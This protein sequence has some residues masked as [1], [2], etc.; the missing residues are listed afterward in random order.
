MSRD[1]L[2]HGQVHVDYGQFYVICGEDDD[3]D[4]ESAFRGQ[5]NGL[6]GAAR[7]GSLFLVT[8][9]RNGPVEITVER[10]PTAPTV[11]DSWEEVVEVSFTAVSNEVA[12]REWD[13]ERYDLA[14]PAGDYRVRYCARGMQ[15]GWDL[16]TVYDDRPV[17]S[18]L[19]Q[20]WPAPACP[21]RIVRQT[22]EI[23][24]HW[25]RE[26][27]EHTGG[28]VA[29]AAALLRVGGA[30]EREGIE[31]QAGGRDANDR[32]SA[33]TIYLGDIRAL[34]ERLLYKLAEVDDATNRAVA[35]W[36]ALRALTAAGLVEIPALLP[37]VAALRSG[38][39]VPAPFDDEFRVVDMLG[40]APQTHVEPI[41]RLVSEVVDDDEDP[42]R[43]LNALMAVVATAR[44]NALEAALDAV[45]YAAIAHGG[46]G[47]ERL[48]HELRATFPELASTTPGSS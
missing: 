48:L 14:L 19:L 25:H 22:S 1:A 6:C 9:L 20:F 11:D 7:P 30:R 36:A 41:P 12:V 16:E 26:H 10:H 15:Q 38:D 27:R 46:P 2:L 31:R 5:V 17:D 37:A 40:E 4:V 21:D 33:V 42:I 28:V 32:L 23:A 43:E 29:P 35:R 47:Y 13:G 34:D 39:R 44:P 24:E 8:G 45:V 3:I 18:Y